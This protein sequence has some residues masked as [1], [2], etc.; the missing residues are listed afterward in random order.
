MKYTLPHYRNILSWFLLISVFGIFAGGCKTT[1]TNKKFEFDDAIRIKPAAQRSYEKMPITGALRDGRTLHGKVVEVVIAPNIHAPQKI[2]TSVIFLANGSED[3]PESYETIPFEDIEPVGRMFNMPRNTY[4]NVNYFEYYNITGEVRE[5]REVPVRISSTSIGS[6]GLGG[7]GGSRNFDQKCNCEPFN[8]SFKCPSRDYSSV[9]IEAHGVYTIFS[10]KP[11][12]YIDRGLTS[13][14]AEIAVG[15]RLGPNREWGIGLAYSTGIPIFNI[16][17]GVE[18]ARPLMLG[19]LRY[20]LGKGSMGLLGFCA[21]P[22][23]YAQGGIALDKATIN[24]TRINLSPNDCSTC[25]QL[26]QKLSATGQL[27]EADFSM[28][29]TFGFGIGLDIPLFSELDVSA[30]IGWR[31]LAIADEIPLAG[32]TNV[33]SNRRVNMIRLGLGLTF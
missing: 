11:S 10:D 2:D 8:V 19:H 25:N 13:W 33:P 14:E 21:R 17:D 20:N 31:S 7:S 30:S 26:I 12:A 23:F 15:Y 22:F 16:S 24:L 4:N 18:I 9:F 28:P 5:L 3:T 1:D 29:I 32:F 6:E 27:P